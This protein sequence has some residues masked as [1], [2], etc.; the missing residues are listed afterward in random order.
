MLSNK[1][2]DQ[3]QVYINLKSKAL[4]LPQKVNGHPL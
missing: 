2:Y 3:T 1:Q 4:P